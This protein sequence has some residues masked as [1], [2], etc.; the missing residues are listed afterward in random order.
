[1]KSQGL[2]F[3]YKCFEEL[4]FDLD[5][6]RVYSSELLQ[7]EYAQK[8]IDGEIIF[9]SSAEIKDFQKN[10]S[11]KILNMDSIIENCDVIDYRQY[12][13]FSEDFFYIIQGVREFFRRESIILHPEK[14]HSILVLMEMELID[15]MGKDH[16][17]LQV[18][19]SYFSKKDFKSKN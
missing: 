2:F 13:L 1:M 6:K 10:S 17:G 7:N 16:K 19:Q 8:L 5:S 15:N 11:G 14:L 18:L 9:L 12:G 4:V 3:S